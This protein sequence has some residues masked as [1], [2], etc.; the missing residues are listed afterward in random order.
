MTASANV[1][2][3]ISSNSVPL[4]SPLARNLRSTVLN[5]AVENSARI[6][7]RSCMAGACP[8]GS[9][10]PNTAASTLVLPCSTYALPSHLPGRQTVV[11]VVVVVVVVMVVVVVVVVVSMI[12]RLE[13]RRHGRTQHYT[14][15]KARLRRRT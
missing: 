4:R 8:V 1:R 14:A 10:G 5:V 11:V 2:S 7:A 12:Q 13:H 3:I 9:W 15:H 6:D